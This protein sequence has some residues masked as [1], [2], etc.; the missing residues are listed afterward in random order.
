MIEVGMAM[1][2]ISV[3]RQLRMNSNTP[4]AAKRPPRIRCSCTAGR[5]P[6]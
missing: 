4:I 2:A 5:K 6:G 1:A 3:E